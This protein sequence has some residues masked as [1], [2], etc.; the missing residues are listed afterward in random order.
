M[1]ASALATSLS[2]DWHTTRFAAPLNFLKTFPKSCE[3]G[4]KSRQR[5]SSKRAAK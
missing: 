1:E 4:Y 5:W 3:R 2:Q